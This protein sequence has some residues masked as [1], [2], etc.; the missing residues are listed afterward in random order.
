MIRLEI[1]RKKMMEENI[2]EERKE[3]EKNYDIERG[4]IG[5]R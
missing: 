3:K 4:G 1:M 2:N 5:K